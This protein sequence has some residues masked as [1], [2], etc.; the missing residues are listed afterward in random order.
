MVRRGDIRRAPVHHYR[1]AAP[2]H[3]QP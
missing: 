1:S 3:H 2:V